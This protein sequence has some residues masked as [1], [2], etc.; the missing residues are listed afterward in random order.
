[1][2]KILT[3][4]LTLAL[5]IGTLAGCAS[6]SAPATEGDKTETKKLKVAVI[7]SG[8]LGDKSFNDSAH[9]GAE[10]AVS[11]YGIELKE[12]ESKEPTEWESNVVAMASDG[13]DLVVCVSTQ[14]QDILKKHAPEFPNTK[15]ALIDGVVAG[16]NIVSSTFAQNEGSFL[17]GAAAAMFTTKTDIPGVNADKTIGWVGG[18]D[19]PVLSDFFVGYEQGAKYID[20][21]IKIL[22]SFAGTFNDPLKGKELTIAQYS[23]GADIVMNVASGTGTG[24]LEAAKEQGKYAVG[25][26]LD[27]D[28]VY[29]GSIL[30]SMLKRVDNA[31]YLAIESVVKGTYKGNSTTYLDIS[32][33]GVGLTDMSVMKQALGDKFPQDILDKM[34]ELQA[35]VKSG[36]IKVN[37][38]EGFGRK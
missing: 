36:E 32:N 7:Y 2:K 6:K 8:F 10:K 29:P 27:Q 34:V 17:A 24:I 15:F 21:D 26:D 31:T 28:S 12:M 13:Y 4:L 33:G 11:D 5:V 23:Q 35:K 25:V 1:M 30:T 14:F 16:D 9:V 37:A 20:P 3:I 22:Q 38:F 18:M 19:I